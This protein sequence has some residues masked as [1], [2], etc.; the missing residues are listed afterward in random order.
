MLQ[1]KRE[2]IL[3]AWA[4]MQSGDPTITLDQI[5]A[6]CDEYRALVKKLNKTRKSQG[7]RALRIYNA[8]LT[9][10]YLTGARFP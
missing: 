7:K 10:R 5:L 6:M 1:S 8:R 4:K 2:E 3:S 9:L